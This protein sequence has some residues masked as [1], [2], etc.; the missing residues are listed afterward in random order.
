[1]N[2]GGSRSLHVLQGF[3]APP[4]V[5]RGAARMY[6]QE[7]N[8]LR[9]GG[10]RHPEERSAR[11]PTT[12]LVACASGFPEG[13]AT[14]RN[15]VRAGSTWFAPLEDCCHADPRT[16]TRRLSRESPGMGEP[17][18]RARPRL[19]SALYALASREG[20]DEAARPA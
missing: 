11:R 15:G 6:D 13:F 17:R 12:E 8:P 10:W 18:K 1:M 9:D 14:Q 16:R 19:A 20:P 3:A 2:T 4:Q 7:V 5:E